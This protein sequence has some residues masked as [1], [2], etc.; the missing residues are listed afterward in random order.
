MVGCSYLLEESI[1]CQ[2]FVSDL[3]LTVGGGLLVSENLSDFT[4][5][6]ERHSKSGDGWQL[7]E[8]CLLREQAT[9]EFRV[10]VIGKICTI[11]IA[12]EP[13]RVESKMFAIIENPPDGARFRVT[14][15]EDHSVVLDREEGRL[16]VSFR[17]LQGQSTEMG[18]LIIYADQIKESRF[19]LGFT[20]EGSLLLQHTV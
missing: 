18:G 7:A 15:F 4:T 3:S 8:S 13:P 6:L 1:L 2:Q 17:P 20:G 16:I 11:R 9:A 19:Y 14:A 12:F 10:Q 5:R